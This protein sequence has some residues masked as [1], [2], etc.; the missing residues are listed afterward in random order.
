MSV[1]TDIYKYNYLMTKGEES[2][3]EYGFT[4]F[5]GN[6][7]GENKIFEDT[8]WHCVGKFLPKTNALCKVTISTF[9]SI[10]IYGSGRFRVLDNNGNIIDTKELEA[11]D[12]QTIEFEPK[13]F[14]QY[15][16]MFQSDKNDYYLV[17][18]QIWVKCYPNLRRWFIEAEAVE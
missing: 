9:N 15:S 11:R 3:S 10:S 5:S 4:I 1:L 6:S 14:T 18:T 16:I 8:N 12:T 13:P 2:G 17:I 7:L